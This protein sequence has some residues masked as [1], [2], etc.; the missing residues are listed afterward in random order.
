DIGS[1][2]VLDAL[3]YAGNLHNIADLIDGKR[4]QFCKGD[5]CDAAL[6]AE[7]FA[8]HRFDCVVHFAAESHV[9]RSI[10]GPQPFLRTNVDGTY[11]L[12]EAARNAWRDDASRR[13]FIHI[14]TDEVFGDLAPDDPPVVEGTPYRPSS[15]YAASKASADHLVRAWGRTYG[16][17]AI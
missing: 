4:L 5:I 1:I 8:K 6:V 16:L 11:V 7:L 9:D 12:I 2:V 15:P 13:R 14:S 3:T 17:P 10:L